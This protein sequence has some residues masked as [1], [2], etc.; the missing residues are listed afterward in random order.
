LKGKKGSI[1]QAPLDK[2]SPPWSEIEKMKWGDI[3]KGAKQNKPGFRTI[4]KLL[5]QGEY[6]K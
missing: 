1:K 2:G 5:T 4:R 6:N 3:E